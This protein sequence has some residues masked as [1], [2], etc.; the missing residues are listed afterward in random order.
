MFIL[1]HLM[2]FVLFPSRISEL[3]QNI[4]VIGYD[5]FLT[6]EWKC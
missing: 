5:E 6:T 4:S 2:F 3:N 1:E